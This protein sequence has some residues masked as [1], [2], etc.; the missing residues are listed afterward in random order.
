[1]S[2]GSP[3]GGLF[4]QR[5]GG[6][7][8]FPIR[9]VIALVIAL[10]GVVSYYS[11]TQVNPVTGEKQHI[12]MSPEQEMALGLQ[13]EPQMAQQMGGEVDPRT[14]RDA[15]TV[16]KI[17][18]RLVY[19]SEDGPKSP[20]AQAKQF[21]FHLLNDSKTVNAFALPGGQVFITRALYDKLENE[22]QLSG[23]IGH[24]VGHVINRHGAEQMSQGELG[25]KIAAAVGVAASDNQGHGQLAAMAAQ[26]ANQMLQ[27]SYSRKDELEADAYGIRLMSQIGYD[28]A[29]ML[30]VMKILEQVSPSGNGPNIMQT[31]P[32]PKDRVIQINQILDKYRAEWANKQWTQGAPLH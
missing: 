30:G 21:H 27:L 11:R 9:I 13:A 25:Q 19:E 18:N 29:Q 10:I 1:M 3:L 31:H 5:S 26:M 32:Y 20:Y 8:G 14:D 6:G 28:P 16:E 12:S 24:E 15:Q 17:G 4:G 23:V 7:G 2:Y 22:A